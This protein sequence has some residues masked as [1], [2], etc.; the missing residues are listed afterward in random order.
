MKILIANWVYNWGST[1][2]I[3]RDLKDEL[4]HTGHRVL[5]ATGRS[6][7]ADDVMVFGRPSEQKMFWRLHR[8]G[9]SPLRGSTN[10][11]KRLIRYIEKETPDVVNLHLLHCNFIN[12][13]Y[14]LQWL[15]THNL[16]TIV[17]NHAE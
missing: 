1:G 14:L 5:V 17:T 4:M 16:K 6:N 15:G 8:I 12:L 3:V 7:E 10:A 13:Y 9:V 11:A 2:Y